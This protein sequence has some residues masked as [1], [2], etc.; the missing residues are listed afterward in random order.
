MAT[1]GFSLA[2]NVRLVAQQQKGVYKR[3]KVCLSSTFFLHAKLFCISPFQIIATYPPKKVIK[4]KSK[5]QS[6]KIHLTSYMEK[7]KQTPFCEPTH[8]PRNQEYQNF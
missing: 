7:Q 6:P 8:S 2:N 5:V 4:K 1:F 3:P